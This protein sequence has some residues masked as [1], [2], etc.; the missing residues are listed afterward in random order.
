MKKLVIIL[1]A[2]PISIWAQFTVTIKAE[3]AFVAKEAYVYTLNG[4]KDILVARE[5]KKNNAWQIKYPKQYSG[6]MKVYFPETGSAV[7]FISEN[8]DVSIFLH[9]TGKKVQEVDYEDEANKLM[10]ETQSLQRR[11]E[12]ILPALYQMKEYYRSGS[13]FGKAMD[14]EILVLSS[15][16]TAGSERYPFI[17]FYNKNYNRFLVS[18]VSAPRPTVD[19]MISFFSN[20]NDLLESSTLMRPVLTEL[21]KSAGKDADAAVDKLLTAVNVESPRGQTILS[22]L[23]ELYD[24]YGMTD[25][26]NKYLSLAKKLK[27]TVFDRLASTI[28]ANANTEIGAVFPNTKFVKPTNTNA[29][30]LHDVKATKK[31]VVFWSSTCSH[32]ETELPQLIPHYRDLKSKGIEII[33]LSLDNDSVSYTQKIQNY[34]WINDSELKGWY[35]SYPEVYNV[36][37]TPTYFILDTQNKIIGKP[38]HVGDVLQELGLK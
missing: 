35:S 14:K 30:N 18:D 29:R 1:T 16:S 22:E 3:P 27:C 9:S 5:Q 38:D 34:P 32:C 13:E 2:L 23:I 26:K 21:L 36:H 25:Q 17:T 4:S 12:V 6:M 19:E 15:K 31:V 33:G 10:D 28:K 8:K 7:N 20:S 11:R 24:T 37:A